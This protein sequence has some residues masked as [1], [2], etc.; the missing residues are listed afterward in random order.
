MND[1]SRHY[2]GR[3]VVGREDGATYVMLA[4]NHVIVPERLYVIRDTD[5]TTVLARV[6][7]QEL[8]DARQSQL[9]AYL[10]EDPNR[11]DTAKV[12]VAPLIKRYAV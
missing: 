1:H 9:D 11:T 2:G 5:H 12:D 7:G 10:Q 3:V 8:L 6:P 4:A